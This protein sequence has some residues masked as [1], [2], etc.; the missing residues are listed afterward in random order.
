MVTNLSAKEPSVSELLT[1]IHPQADF[2]RV[3]LTDGNADMLELM[4]ANVDIVNESH[5]LVE[6]TSW[7]FRVGHATVLH[8]TKRT[9]DDSNYLAAVDTGI[10]TF[11]AITAMVSGIAATSDMLTVNNQASKLIQTDGRQLDEYMESSVESFTADMPRTREVIERS[12][13]RF[14]GHLTV[15]AMLGAAMSRQFELACVDPA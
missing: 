9:Y 3:D 11:E 8:G 13:R 5:R 1:G 10:V 7:I 15:Y 6:D 2:P 4:M 12:A 14:H